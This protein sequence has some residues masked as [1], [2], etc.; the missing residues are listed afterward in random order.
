MADEYISPDSP[1]WTA[2]SNSISADQQIPDGN[3]FDSAPNLSG[4]A[5]YSI[6]DRDFAA[7]QQAMSDSGPDMQVGGL[8]NAQP[9]SGGEEKGFSLADPMK[10]MWNSLFDSK[11]GDLNKA[12]S[13][14]ASAVLSG[15]GELFS[16]S[17]KDMAS[18]NKQMADAATLNAQTNAARA[19]DLRAEREN[20]MTSTA[21]AFGPT[22][23]PA[24][25]I[26]RAQFKKLDKP[27][28]KVA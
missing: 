5:N 23:G 17:K 10:A 28:W 14:A 7:F 8:M 20:A 27:T 15:L 18:R 25:L 13:L 11:T 9:R 6:I 3:G 2:D 26:G 19:A 24:G 16:G 1:D 22:S 4:N 21:T 12:G